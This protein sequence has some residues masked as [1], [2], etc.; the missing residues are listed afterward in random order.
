MSSTATRRATIRHTRRAKAGDAPPEAHMEALRQFAQAAH[1]R[2]GESL[3]TVLAELTRGLSDR[4]RLAV[5]L[6]ALEGLV[7]HASGDQV[8]LARALDPE[9][10]RDLASVEYRA[11]VQ[12]ALILGDRLGF[13]G[14]TTD[15][16]GARLAA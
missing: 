13:G 16:E 2:R 12:F 5:A 3:A 10:R 11:T 9:T 7:A 6:D 1:T 14:P 8:A 15:D 4:K